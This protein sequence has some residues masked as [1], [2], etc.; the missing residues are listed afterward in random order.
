[1]QNFPTVGLLDGRFRQG[2]EETGMGFDLEVELIRLA[3]EL[4]LLTTPYVFNS[5]TTVGD[6]RG[7]RGRASCPTSGTTTSGMIG[8]PTALSLDERREF[9]QDAARRGRRREPDVIV[10]CHGGPIAEPEDAA[11]VLDR[12]H[13]VAG[14]FGAS[15][16]ERLPAERGDHRAGPPF[17]A[18][19]LGTH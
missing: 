9:V 18:I 11:Y 17:K 2:L 14:F 16:M 19:T 15:S 10:L 5:P 3:R 13:G 6:G 12:T 8:A 7:R 4:D 1:M